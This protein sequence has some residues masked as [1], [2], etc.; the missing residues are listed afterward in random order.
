MGGPE[1]Q[2]QASPEA[3]EQQKEDGRSHW[4]TLT[5]EEQQDIRSAGASWWQNAP[6]NQR[7]YS[8]SITDCPKWRSTLFAQLEGAAT[9]SQKLSLKMTITCSLLLHC[10]S[11]KCTLFHI[12]TNLYIDISSSKRCIANFS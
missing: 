2:A 10:K 3:L 8:L 1:W 12:F 4:R 11:Y 6:M 5:E 9:G 7:C